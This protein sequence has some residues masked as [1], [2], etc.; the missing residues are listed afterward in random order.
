MDHAASRSVPAVLDIAEVA[1]RAGLAPSA[2]RYYEKLG[3]LE[4]IGRN[5]LRRTYD[6]TALDRIA[7]IVN[8]QA[9]GFSLAEVKALVDA[10]DATVRATL[11]A[12]AD[13]IEDRIRVMQQQRR[14]LGH[15]LTCEHES[16]LECP[17]FQAGLRRALPG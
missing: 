3:L 6:A 7:L 1:E 16:I 14:Q 10:D 12:K 8:A 13:E 9:T 11:V 2:L 17:T 15:A 5:G 4:P